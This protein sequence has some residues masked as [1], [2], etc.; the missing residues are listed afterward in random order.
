MHLQLCGNGLLKY[1]CEK[2]GKRKRETRALGGE[3]IKYNEI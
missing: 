2:E 1:R 3:K